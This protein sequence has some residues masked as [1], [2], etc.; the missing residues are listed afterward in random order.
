LR[1]GLSGI[2]EHL[3]GQSTLDNATALHDHDPVRQQAR[4]SKIMGY[5]NGGEVQFADEVA[6]EVEQPCLHGDI[7]TAGRLI[8]E[9]QARLGDEVARDL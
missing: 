1:I 4:Y 8:H 3:I 7:E 2:V 5:H 6:Q 9:Y